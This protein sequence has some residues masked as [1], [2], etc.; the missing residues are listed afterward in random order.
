MSWSYDRRKGWTAEDKI[1]LVGPREKPIN[2][3]MCDIN[4]STPST[5]LLYLSLNYLF[6]WLLVPLS[7]SCHEKPAVHRPPPPEWKQTIHTEPKRSKLE[8]FLAFDF[9]ARGSE[10]SNPPNPPPFHSPI[11][12]LQIMRD[13][14]ARSHPPLLARPS[15]PPI[16]SPPTSLSSAFVRFAHETNHPSDSPLTPFSSSP[17]SSSSLGRRKQASMTRENVQHAAAQHSFNVPS[18]VKAR[19][20]THSNRVR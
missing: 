15:L 5:S 13:M 10:A 9:L 17:L 6:F 3:P 19:P 2:H 8:I 11:H 16:S 7:F 4:I 12:K 18:E 20:V 14:G 1:L